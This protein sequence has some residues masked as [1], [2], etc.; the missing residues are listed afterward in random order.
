MNSFEIFKNKAL[1]DIA[2]VSNYET[3]MDLFKKW[4]VNNNI[5]FEEIDLSIDGGY[6]TYINEDE[7]RIIESQFK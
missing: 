1:I 2:Y 5:A 7:Y 4:L 6:V 3:K